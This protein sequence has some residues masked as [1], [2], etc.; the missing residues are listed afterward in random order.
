[1]VWISECI[2]QQQKD[3]INKFVP[4]FSKSAPWRSE[5]YVLSLCLGGVRHEAPI[6]AHSVAAMA[7]GKACRVTSPP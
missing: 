3:E 1:M 6:I 5:S 4:C 7:L 2:V